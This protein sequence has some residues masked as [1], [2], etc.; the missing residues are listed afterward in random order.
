MAELI[1]TAPDGTQ[2]WRQ[3]LVEGDTV[4]LGRG[5][6]DGW[7]ANWDNQISREHIELRW[8]AGRLTVK[9]LESARNPVFYRGQ[10]LRE[11]SLGAGE[12]FVIGTS[13]FHVT[14]ES[15][16]VSLNS[17]EPRE[18]H[19]FRPVSYTHLTLPTILRV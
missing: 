1:A 11:F 8:Q 17:P 4:R 3:T 9:L 5:P 10:A 16:D 7:S 18:E 19:T 15:A 12:H 6:A 14:A 13:S 2:R